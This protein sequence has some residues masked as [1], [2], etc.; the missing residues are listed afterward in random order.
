M[1]N[2]IEIASPTLQMKP[3]QFAKMQKTRD[4]KVDF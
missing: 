4:L 1:Q 2:L 3:F